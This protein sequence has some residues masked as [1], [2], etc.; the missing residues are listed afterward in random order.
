M[1]A[2]A[3]PIWWGARWVG[4]RAWQ[5]AGAMLSRRAA[6]RAAKRAAE[7][8]AAEAAARA[9]A[10]AKAKEA[11]ACPE[12]QGECPVCGKKGGKPPAEEPLW[13]KNK[14]TPTASDSILADKSQFTKLR[15][16]HYHGSSA[17]IEKS[18]GNIHYIDGLH[19]NM[20]GR[21]E[22]EVFQPKRPYK[23]LGTKCPA[24]GADLDG[25]DPKKRLP[26]SFR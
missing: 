10:E 17:F 25:P 5:G 1:G 20:Q 24:C 4:T 15:G 2:V 21:A 11:E 9:A 7:K 23:H 12:C 16:R 14:N 13:S 22:I 18:T 26:E 8:A 3:A 6:R 19:G